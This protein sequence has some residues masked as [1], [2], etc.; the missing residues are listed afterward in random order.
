MN[1]LIYTRVSTDEQAEKGFSLRHQKQTLTA[2]AESNN[3]NIVQSFEE[4]YS[5]KNFDRPEWKKLMD[6]AKKNK[7]KVDKI[8][9]SKWDRFSR[10]IEQAL[11]VIRELTDMGIEVNALEQPLDLNIPD[12]KVMLAMY[13][14]IPEVEND[15]I[16]QRTKDGM[17]RA[18]LEGC[19]LAKAPFGYDNAKIDNKTSIVP[20][21]D[22]KL[23]LTAFKE[24]AKGYEAVE[25]IRKR[26][27]EE[28]N[29]KLEKQQFYNM[30]RNIT[31]CGT[32]VIP[33][34]KK[35]PAQFIQGLHEPIVTSE[36]F[37]T[38]QDVINGRKKKGVKLPTTVNVNFP[39][40]KNLICP[41]C[42]KQI[43]GSKSKGNGGYYEYYHCKSKCKIRLAKQSVHNNMIDFLNASSLNSNIQELY[44]EVLTDL[45]NQNESHTSKELKQLSEELKNNRDLLAKA[46][47]K[48]I[49]DEIDQDAYLRASARYK[50]KISEIEGKILSLEENNED[51]LQYVDKAVNLLCNLGNYFN[52]LYNKDKDPFLRV[53]YPKNLI[54]EENGFRTENQNEVLELLT[55][56]FK[57]SEQAK[58]KKA[59]KSSGFSNVAPPLGLEPRTL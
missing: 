45:I 57:G 40:K 19:F 22:A 4:D 1:I 59:T 35:E 42:G 2:Y 3:L 15:K 33:E 58:I 44:K 49:A 7:N 10:N 21:Q 12:N 9:F 52:H 48:R 31:Y 34:Y 39:I 56:V 24:V 26:L 54:L 18:K 11:A 5:A 53:I 36:L 37:N 17:R 8:L 23:V 38:V 25:V 28:F 41:K 20:N 47:D 30:L 32:I 43:T 29:L 13:L 14:I 16:S 50:E 46:D 51:S 55:R 6:Y 27:K